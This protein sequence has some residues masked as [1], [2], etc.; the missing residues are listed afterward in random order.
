MRN[1][2]SLEELRA[3]FAALAAN[4]VPGDSCPPAESIWEALRGGASPS[5]TESVVAHMAECSAC[6]ESWR[7]GRAFAG[8]PS[9]VVVELRP[10]GARW[11]GALGL[12]AAA[13]VVVAGLAIERGMRAPEPIVMRAGEESSI[14]SLVPETETLSRHDCRLR[15]S[16]AGSGARYIVRVG[17]EDLSIIA[18]SN[19]LESPEYVVP[20]KSLEKVPSGATILW[21]VEASLPDGRKLASPA[22][23][24]R[25]E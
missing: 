4:A 1:D 23:K 6:A 9:P 2:P 13:V 8:A 15:W 16:D 19:S 20:E 12:A 14:R 3:R 10:R 18:T 24:H 11:W 22:F 21:R 7:L 17:A 5:E 25:V